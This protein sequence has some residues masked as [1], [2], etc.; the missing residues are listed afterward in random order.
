MRDL[1]LPQNKAVFGIKVTTVSRRA[2][3]RYKKRS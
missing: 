1:E 3:L 2:V